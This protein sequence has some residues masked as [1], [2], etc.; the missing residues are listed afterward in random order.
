[1]GAADSGLAINYNSSAGSDYVIIKS[2]NSGDN[3][4]LQSLQLSDY[5]GNDVKIE[6]FDNGV[7][8]GSVNVTVNADPWYFTF[9]ENG[10]L[11]PT[12]F[13]NVD[14]IRISGQ[15]GGTIWLTVNN[16]Q[17]AAPVS[18]QAPTD[19]ALSNSSV[20]ESAGVNATVGT[21]STTD[22]DAGD[23]HTY[24]LVTGTGDDNNSAFNI[25]GDTLR[26]NDAAALPGGNYSVRIQ[27]DDGNGGTFAKSFTIGVVDDLAPAAPTSFSAGATSN[28]VALAWVD[29]ADADF[30]S[31]TIRRSS[32]SFPTTIADGTLVASGVTGTSQPDNGLADGTYYYS[33]FALDGTG[34]VSL[35]ATASITVD[36]VAPTL[37]IGAPSVTNTVSGPVDFTVTYTG[38]D[39]VTLANGDITL[40]KTGTADATSI[41]VSGSGTTTRTV[42]LSGISGSGTLGISLAAGTAS[43]TAGNAAAAAGPSAT[44][45][46]NSVP[47]AGSDNAIITVG[48]GSTATNSGTF[49]DADGN[50]TV[51]LTA[52]VG[53][54][55]PDNN[56]GTWSWSLT[57]TN[58]PAESQ[59]VTITANDGMAS[60]VTTTFDLVVTNVP[61]TAEVQDISVP[62][63]TATNI[64]LTATDPGTDTITNW[65]VTLDPTNGTLSGT[66]PN[67]TYTPA[68]NFNGTDSFTFTAT[69]SD[70]ATSAVATV[71]LTVTPV[72]DPPV[73]GSDTATVTVGE[74]ATAANTGTFADP[75]GNGTVTLSASVGTVTPDNNAGTWSWSLTTTNGPAESQTV[76][77]TADDGVS[78]PVTTTFDLVVTNV[79]P[80]AGAQ[81]ITT[82]EDT[83]T[84]ITL[85]ATDPGTDTITNWVVTAGPTNGTLS[86]TAP[87]LTYTPATNFNGT[88]SFSFTATDSDGATSATATV[89]ITVPPVNDPPV[90]GADSLSR[91]DNTKLVKV[92]KAALLAND[93][94]PDNDPLSIAG[95]GNALP[96]GATVTMAGNFVMYNAPA[97]NAGDGSFTYTLSDGPGGHF[98]TN[99]VPI[100][101]VAST[102]TGAGP[103]YA[104]I[105]PSGSD[106][107]LTFIGVPNHTYRVQYTTSASAPYTWNEFS[108]LAILTA[109]T[110]GVFQY[111]D[112]NPPGPLRL[113]RAVPH[114]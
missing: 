49:S 90:A 7:S 48:E 56:A 72:N 84:N 3:F 112:T 70:G 105:A 74:G 22:A 55:T 40:N 12:I 100:I 82:P 58:G 15:A 85:T 81:A 30:A 86:G 23:S 31:V 78:T 110:N 69:D 28:N 68:T 61:P 94:D 54:V 33:I 27:T 77:I 64:T 51:T 11:T 38:A 8:Q 29:P 80:T 91:L 37:V 41:V 96:A 17:I 59:T 6:A 19:M 60:P 87:N 108:P 88:D 114:P 109:P 35:A 25:S 5:G 44:F 89:S 43:D 79:P 113:Y 20:N 92:T 98:V 24:S 66:A 62:E 16:I 99:T 52:S 63:D 13:H 39:T 111:T 2:R 103:N 67:L 50:A 95:V 57:T 42:T 46:A 104:N 76:T 14:E 1:V 83:A 10:A 106:Y 71:S 107:V 9:D 65:V 47:V 101:Q 4:W 18:N 53:T 97:T 93:T 102:P 26:A 75:D 34:N 21:L 45:V 32:T 73:V 36:T